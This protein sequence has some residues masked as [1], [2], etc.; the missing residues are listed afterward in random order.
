VTAIRA[1]CLVAADSP[2]ADA[3]WLRAG[4]DG[5]L[6]GDPV[7]ICLVEGVPLPA[8]IADDRPVLVLVD[9]WLLATGDT[10]VATATHDRLRALGRTAALLG[11]GAPGEREPPPAIAPLLAGWLAADAAAGAIT[12]QLRGALRHAA[13]LDGERRRTRELHELTR[14]GV[15]LSTERDLVTVLERILTQARRLSGCDAGS[16]YLAEPGADG[17][18]GTLRFRI[19][20]NASLPDLPFTEYTIPIDH[21]SLAGYAAVTG[22]ALS[23]PDVYALPVDAVYRQNRTFDERFGYHTRSVLVLPM[24]THRDEV[25]G[26]LQLI[27]RM[28]RPGVILSTP[29][30]TDAEVVPFDDASVT[31]VSALASLGAVAIENA[32][33]YEDIER[34]FEGFVTAAVTAIE[35]RDPSTHG[36]SARVA[37]LSVALAEAVTRDGGRGAHRGLAFTRE[38][39][40]EL[41]YA[42]LLHDFGKVGVREDVLTKEKKLYPRGLELI[43]LRLLAL[44]HDADAAFE[45]ARAEHL[46]R[47]GA[48]GYAEAVQTLEAARRTTLGALDRYLRAVMVANEPAP[49]SDDALDELRRLSRLTYRDI[50][51]DEREVLTGEEFRLLTIRRGTLDEAER[52]E[53]ESHVGHTQRF[54]TQIPWTAPLR[55]VPTIAAAHHEKLNGTGYPAG[56]AGAS[57]PIQTRILTIVD[58]FDALTAADRPYKRAVSPE[59]ALA[60]LESE[61]AAGELDRDLLATFIGARLYA[62]TGD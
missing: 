36:H 42:G 62:R 27:N 47:A 21:T 43:R 16:L 59:R 33:L 48:V 38:Q 12:V 32:R 1:L 31:L 23:V 15:A 45:R 25:V 54:L 8:T 29:A 7:D 51:G 22:T 19:A 52:R 18:A 28:R 17:G 6:E 14:V 44:R 11:I 55:A 58:I 41:R 13:A 37:R 26:V 50:G 40:R 56:L 57:I 49:L 20:Q 24:K 53:I 61:A 9:R 39:L 34:L 30:I 3:P 5:A 46:E 10:R 35:S 4:L 2:I 60:I